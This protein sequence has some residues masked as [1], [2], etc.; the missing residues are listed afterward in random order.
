VQQAESRPRAEA[1]SAKAAGTAS[2]WL[3]SDGPAGPDGKQ[4]ASSPH[5][6]PLRHP[7]RA[8]LHILVGLG[9]CCGPCPAGRRGK[10]RPLDSLAHRH[11][12]ARGQAGEHGQ[13][14]RQF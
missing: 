14:R 1:I 3:E 6:E 5:G 8:G 7:A 11:L 12:H 10:S 4:P 9:A 13:H 2:T